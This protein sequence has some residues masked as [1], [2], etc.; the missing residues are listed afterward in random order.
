MF[1]LGGKGGV[2][3]CIV[4]PQKTSFKDSM[5]GN[6]SPSEALF[7]IYCFVYIGQL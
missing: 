1:F 4:L 2:P 6:F 7:S 5:F 3:N